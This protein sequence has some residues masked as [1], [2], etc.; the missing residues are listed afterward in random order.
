MINLPAGIS[1]NG[2]VPALIDF[3]G[4][5]RPSLGARALKVNR[6]GSRFRIACSLPPMLNKAQGRVC[7]SRL[8]QAKREGM[9]VAFPL[10][11]V[12]QS[13]SGAPVVNGANQAG[14]GINLRGVTPGWIA[15]EGYWLS[16]V[17]ATGQHYLHIVRA[18]SAPAAGTSGLSV[19]IEPLLR[20]PFADGA[21]VNFT[22]PMIE[23]FVDGDEI[24]W[25]MSLAHHVGIEFMIEEA[26]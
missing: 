18:D 13:G 26:A 24:G 1:L 4:V 16:I 20:V 2:G 3:G 9:R 12:D 14:L 21:T 19:A 11:G 25:E 17:D 10:L 23:G 6:L 8:L 22:Q 5:M 7:V 15:R